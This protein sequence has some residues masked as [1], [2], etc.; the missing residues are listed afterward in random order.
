MPIQHS[1]FRPAWWLRCAHAQTLYPHLCRRPEDIP[2]TPERLEL[3]DGDFVDLQWAGP[4][5]GP[6]V[7]LFHGLEGSGDSSYIRGLRAALA[8][9]GLASVLMQFRGCSGEPNRLAR[10]YHSGDT[11]DIRTLLS[12]LH[13]RYPDRWLGAVGFSLGGNALLKYL[14]ESAAGCPLSQAVAVSV[15]F[16]LSRCADRLAKGVSRIYTR[17]LLNKLNAKV[18]ARRELLSDNGVDVDAA[19]KTRDFRGFDGAVVAPIFGFRDAEDYYTQS[20][21]GPFLSRIQVPTLILQAVDDP[22]MASS[23]IPT[24]SDLSPEVTLELSE[25]GGHVGF[26][27]GA[28]PGM[29]DYWLDRRITQALT[30]AAESP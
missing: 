10:A 18:A 24:Q 23:A 3:P 19:L 1:A 15:P 28:A 6:L 4:E 21:C 8:Q 5:D 2:W 14:G 9:A 27:A 16:D 7:C 29:A 12:T 11:G 25:R 22:F 30:A 17:H 13:R 26:V 20:S